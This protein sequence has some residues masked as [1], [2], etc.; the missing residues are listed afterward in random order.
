M[1]P[2]EA[3]DRHRRLD[4]IRAEGAE[5]MWDISMPDKLQLQERW[6]RAVRQESFSALS[7]RVHQAAR[8][9]TAMYELG[10][11]PEICKHCRG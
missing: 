11:S 8:E 7:Q 2:I 3:S 4:G 5:P 10:E 9:Q 6:L 1:V